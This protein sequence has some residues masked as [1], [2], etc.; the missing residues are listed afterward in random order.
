[1]AD[2]STVLERELTELLDQERFDPPESFPRAA[3]VKDP[4]TF[5]AAA[6]DP[7]AWWA[8]QARDLLDWS[9][10]FTEGLD[11]SN[12]PFFTWFADGELNASY[13]CVDRHVE[14][15]LGDRVAFHW[16]G[17]EVER[18]DI[19]YADLHRDVQRF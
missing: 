17:E 5:A 3:A 1:M 11:E 13:N 8:E 19:T 10:P 14:A 6:E 2:D 7:E 15:G 16:H 9:T 18:R 4:A 12:P